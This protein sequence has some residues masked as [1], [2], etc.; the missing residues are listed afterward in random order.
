MTPA[1]VD[2]AEAMRSGVSESLVFLR[3]MIELAQT[4]LVAARE[5]ANPEHSHYCLRAA[6]EFHYAVE[7]Q[8]TRVEL[9]QLGR[10]EI[11]AAAQMLDGLI[12][13]A[14]Y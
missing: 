6:R 8:L 12:G 2:S 4:M 7:R 3:R 13:Q 9:G 5:S 14:G 11:E 1:G 10:A